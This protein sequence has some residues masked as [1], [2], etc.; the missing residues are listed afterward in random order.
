MQAVA[1]FQRW[2]FRLYGPEAAPIVLRQ[3]R[4]YVLPTGAGLAYAVA[5]GFMLIGAI[6]YNLSLGYALVFLLAGLGL[7]TL[8]H[9]FR[10]LVQLEISPGRTEPVFAGDAAHFGLCLLNRRPTGRPAISLRLAGG[11]WIS[12]DL[13]ADATTAIS[14]PLPAPR[15]GWLR[16]GRLTLETR[17]P[18]CLLRAWSYVE[19]DMV[20]LVYPRPE[21]AAPPL[22]VSATGELGGRLGGIG[23]EDFSGLRPHQPADSPRHVAWKAVAREQPLL[24]KQF[25]GASSADIWLDWNDL[26]PDMQA[27]ARLS[28]LTRWVLDAH[29]LGLA[30]GLSLPGRRLPSGHGPTHFQDCLEALALHGSPAP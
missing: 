7:V 6:N 18:L 24:S 16:C 5:L 8:L 12:A 2:L 21:V 1:S 19:P 30:W 28:R 3:R 10:N 4:I 27:E 13:A 15:R 26:P 25:A 20:C 14:L 22:P 29:A 9:T 23:T 11:D 17:Y